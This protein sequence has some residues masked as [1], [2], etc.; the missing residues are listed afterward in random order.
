MAVMS[1]GMHSSI[2]G[3]GVRNAALLMDGQGV[4]V[5]PKSDCLLGVSLQMG[6]H[7]RATCQIA[8]EVYAGAFEFLANATTRSVFLVHDLG[9]SV[10]I[11]PELDEFGENGIDVVPDG[12]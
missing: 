9:M 8:L 7:A 4:D 12:C 5:G 6:K 11:M 3:G 2:D 1:A 10:K